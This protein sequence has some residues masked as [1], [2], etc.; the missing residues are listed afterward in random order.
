MTDPQHPEDATAGEPEAGSPRRALA[1]GA[2][3]GRERCPGRGH[4][5]DGARRGSRGRGGAGAGS[6]GRGCAWPGTRPG[7]RDR[8]SDPS[9][10][11]PEPEPEPE[12]V[13]AEPESSQSRSR[14]PRKNRSQLRKPRT[15]SRSPSRPRRRPHSRKP[16]A[17]A[18][19]TP[20][21]AAP[22]EKP[23]KGAPVSATPAPKVATIPYVDDRFSKIWIAIIVATF[24]LIFA[25]GIIFSR[26]GFLIRSRPSRPCRARSRH[27]APR[28]SRAR[29]PRWNRVASAAPSPTTQP[30]ASVEASPSSEASP[31]GSASPSP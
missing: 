30:S 6:R 22:P 29:A 12:P 8:T 14:K 3:R 9:R 7:A 20:E 18:A 31:A 13:A 5:R 11:G 15:R 27:R 17:A 28:W 4:R 10:A 26:G 2:R 24:A 1:R 16:R 25:F 21:F 23:Q 19:A